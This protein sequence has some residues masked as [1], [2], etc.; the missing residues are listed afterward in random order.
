[1]ASNSSARPAGIPSRI[2]TSAWPCDSPAVRKRSIERAFYLKNLH[3]PDART[4]NG[5]RSRGA[6]IL[7]PPSR[8]VKTAARPWRIATRRRYKEAPVQ[9]LADRFLVTVGVR[10]DAT[11]TLK[12]REWQSAVDLSTGEH[13]TLITSPAGG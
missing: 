13:V 10:A 4:A 12:D 7:H 6:V 2:V 3:T 8:F 1:M 11:P 9:P 5:A